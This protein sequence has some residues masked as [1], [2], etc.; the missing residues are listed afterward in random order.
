M[1]L[2]EDMKKI[3]FTSEQITERCKELGEEITKDYQNKNPLIVGVLKG[4]MP[5]MQELVKNIDL[6]CSLD[7]IICSS[8][9]GTKSTGL[10]NIVKD[11]TQP[12]EGKDIIIVEDIVDSGL[13][14]KVVKS[15][16]LERGARSVKI[17]TLLDKKEGRM[18][19]LVPDYI[20][21]DVA[22]EFVVG[23]GLDYNEFYRNVPY[24]GVLKEEVYSK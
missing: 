2:D 22:N 20:A 4:A 3:L 5:F 21:F 13:T 19:E 14:L 6:Y 17:A 23:F 10:V 16:F 15:M 9:Q 8:Y 18:Y 7:Y 12:L 24:V 1:N 11:V